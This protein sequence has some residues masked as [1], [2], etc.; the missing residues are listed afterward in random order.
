[1]GPG[2]QCNVGPG[3]SPHRDPGLDMGP[4]SSSVRSR[5]GHWDKKWD[6]GS[7]LGPGPDSGSG[8]RKPGKRKRP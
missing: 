5:E 7:I 2:S 3:P 6:P 4:V 8:P 1:M